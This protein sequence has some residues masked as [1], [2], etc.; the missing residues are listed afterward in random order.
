MGVSGQKR[1]KGCRAKA[2]QL[3]NSS[4]AEHETDNLLVVKFNSPTSTGMRVQ[5]EKFQLSNTGKTGVGAPYFGHSGSSDPIIPD[6]AG[7]NWAWASRG[8]AAG[9]PGATGTEILNNGRHYLL[10]QT[11]A[12]LKQP[13]EAGIPGQRFCIRLGL[14]VGISAGRKQRISGKTGTCVS[15]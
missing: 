10:S 1:A 15:G 11:K 12:E 9:W 7:T 3:L 8:S 6:Q 4:R 5:A 2:E 13:R 14:A